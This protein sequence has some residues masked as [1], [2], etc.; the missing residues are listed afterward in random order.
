AKSEKTSS[1]P[2]IQLKY[3]GKTYRPEPNKAV[4]NS[5]VLTYRGVSYSRA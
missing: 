5:V 2:T 1:K 4:R 3:M